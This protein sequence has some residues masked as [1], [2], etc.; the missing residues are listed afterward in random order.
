MSTQ[1]MGDVV[2]NMRA[3]DVN[4]SAAFAKAGNDLSNIASKF[5]S[6][7]GLLRIGLGSN[8]M[9]SLFHEAHE[10]AKKF[11]EGVTEGIGASE[12]LGGVLQSGL[13]KMFGLETK[14][15]AFARHMKE[16]AEAAEKL[17]ALREIGESFN[18][19]GDPSYQVEA[20]KKIDEAMKK[21][22]EINK[23]AAEGHSKIAALQQKS[24]EERAKGFG[25]GTNPFTTLFQGGTWD[26]LIIKAEKE[27][28]ALFEEQRQAEEELKRIR[29]EAEEFIGRKA[30]E[31]WEEKYIKQ[32]DLANK[33]YE[34][35]SKAQEDLAKEQA[36]ED[37]QW[38]EARKKER[39]EEK[40]HKDQM[41][42]K[43][44][45]EAQQIRDRSDPL[46]ALR[47][48][49][50]KAEDLF[51]RGF[52]SKQE[53]DTDF[54]H[55]EQQFGQR[56]RQS[57]MFMSLQEMA[58]RTQES[59]GKQEELKPNLQRMEDVLKQIRDNPQVARM[60]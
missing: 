43:G 28:G 12:N 26:Q 60:T 18:N 47:D 32:V 21:V 15:E 45:R 39:E 7:Q 29:A 34:K 42:E 46:A 6:F 58:R 10:E 3:N 11:F 23:K 38:I 5:G 31:A 54:S 8:V 14:S 36:R 52:L 57:P 30:E 49:A 17:A 48:E 50:T 24:D 56:E 13:D 44:Q 40:K 33:L 55:L 41:I 22:E 16:S 19:A 37:E 1:T 25:S 27:Y 59:Q 9:R 51:R 2:I 20:D 53:R 4:M 35:E